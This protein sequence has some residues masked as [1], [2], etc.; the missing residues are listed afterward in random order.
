M[1]DENGVFRI[2]D[3]NEENVVVGSKLG[4]SVYGEGFS[5]YPDSYSNRPYFSVAEDTNG[6]RLRTDR[7]S[8]WK[9]DRD[10]IDTHRMV[11]L[12][13]G[14]LDF[15][16]LEQNLISD[17]SFEEGTVY[18]SSPV[19]SILPTEIGGKLIADS[20]T[21][22]G[23]NGSPS[24]GIGINEPQYPLDID[25][26]VNTTE[27]VQMGGSSGAQMVYNASENSVSFVF[28]D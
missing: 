13:G 11:T 20:F 8:T 2:K 24:I 9:V 23:M 21:F 17:Y 26:L 6:F 5:L 3:E 27:G 18:G 28:F 22:E 1:L 4:L 25:G 12:E 14:N 10:T 19:M 16:M 15:R 7:I